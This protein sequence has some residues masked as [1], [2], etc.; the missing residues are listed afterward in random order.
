MYVQR[1]P[2]QHSR[3]GVIWPVEGGRW[4]VGVVGMG[5]DY[6]PADEQECLPCVFS[7]YGATV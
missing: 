1:A 2:P 6:S 5:R 4:M 3:G 7:M